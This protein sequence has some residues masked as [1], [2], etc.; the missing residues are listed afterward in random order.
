MGD[1]GAFHVAFH[2]FDTACV[3]DEMELVAYVLAFTVDVDPF[4]DIAG[5]KDF[6]G[7]EHL[8]MLAELKVVGIDKGA[9]D[10]KVLDGY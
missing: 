8:D 6:V 3:V 2:D 1:E 9:G 7:F 10:G 4:V 5:H